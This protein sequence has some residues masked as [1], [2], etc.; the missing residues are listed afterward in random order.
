MTP[1]QNKCLE[2]TE[3]LVTKHWNYQLTDQS[4]VY[5]LLAITSDY[6]VWEDR[7]VAEIQL[8]YLYTILSEKLK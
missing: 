7:P 3:Y 4:L 2:I 6:V 8:Q 5:L 1:Y